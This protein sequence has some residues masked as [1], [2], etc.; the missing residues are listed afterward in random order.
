MRKIMAKTVDYYIRLPY[1][2]VIIPPDDD[3]DT[4]FAEIPELSGCNTY[5]ENWV[6]LQD[7]IADA[8]RTRISFAL[9][10]GRT[11]PEPITA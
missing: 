10:D 2:I 5:A 4:W 7:M 11:I 6:E 3:E 1:R 9:E 8:K